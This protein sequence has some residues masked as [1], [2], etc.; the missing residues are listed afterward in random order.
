MEKLLFLAS[1][2]LAPVAHGSVVEFQLYSGTRTLG[3]FQVELYDQDKPA[4]VNNFFHYVESGGYNNSFF[5]RNV[6]G[7][8]VQGGGY[9][10][11][12]PSLTNI[13]TASNV[14][15]VPS[16]GTILGE[17]NS[18]NFYSNTNGTLAMALSSGPNTATSEFFFNM[19]D[20]DG[21]QTNAG[22]SGVNLDDTSD[23][24]PFTVFGRVTSGLTNL[25]SVVNYPVVDATGANAALNTLPVFEGNNGDTVQPPCNDLIYYSI[26]VISAQVTVI[27]VELKFS[28]L[29]AGNKIVFS[30]PAVF[31]EYALESTASLGRP[32]W[33]LLTNPV[34]VM[35]NSNFTVTITNVGVHKYFRLIN[36]NTP[37]LPSNLS[38]IPAGSFTMGDTFNEDE[39]GEFPL[40]TVYVSAF[41]IDQFDVTFALWQQVYVWATRHGY[42]FDNPGAGK[43]AN[44][45]VWSIEWYDAVK[46]CNA[47]SEIEGRTPAYYTS[48]AQTDV[49]RTGDL[50]LGNDCVNWNA[51]Y[52]LPTEAEW[53][54]AA[55]G[56]QSGLR[57]PW[58][59]TI[60]WTNANYFGDPLSLDP[61]VGYAY[62]F[63]TAIDYDPAFTNGVAPYTSP[64]G[65][66][67]PNGYGLYDMV[68]NVWQWIW[69]WPNS[70][71]TGSETDPRGP[72][73]GS[74][75][76]VVRGGFNAFSCRN[77]YRDQDGLFLLTY[78]QGFRCVR[79]PMP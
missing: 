56:G 66:F 41:E 68:G 33:A 16:F 13:I 74:D 37:V 48:A 59:N 50:D 28:F 46:W 8:I 7:F 67:P 3:T 57:F 21:T 20:N 44:H 1:V 12:T 6:P 42:T 5:H 22:Q 30:W 63:S 38:L 54:K 64:V 32:S 4:T 78:F 39:G 69:D 58:G 71:A 75:Y 45:P 31:S 52:R 17:A 76:R 23:G 18:G 62:D 77:A 51:G 61:N 2:F 15:P 26:K 70:Y 9:F 25:E 10:C 11:T 40:H 36:T 72:T 65:Y 43:A 35:A 14:E 53:E 55:R 24:G 19:V 49:Y 47:R 27:P 79:A 34:P 29:P 73:T 60:S